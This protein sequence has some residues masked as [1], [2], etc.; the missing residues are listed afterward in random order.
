[1]RSPARRAAVLFL[2]SL[3]VL[4]GLVPAA[5]GHGGETEGMDMG[6]DMGMDTTVDQARPD[7]G[8]YPPTYFTHPE[9]RGAIYA[10]IALMVVSWVFMLPV[11]KSISMTRTKDAS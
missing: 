6:M 4:L 7:E 1:M 8:D 11:G 2:A 3:A 9:H 5:L 10:H